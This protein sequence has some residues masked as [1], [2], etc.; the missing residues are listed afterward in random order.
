MFAALSVAGC[1]YYP[2]AQ[3]N[4]RTLISSLRTSLS[5]EQPE[6]LEQNVVE[7]D[8]RFQ[9]GELSQEEYDAFQSIIAKAKSGDWD[10][11]EVDSVAFQRAQVRS[12]D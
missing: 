1:N 5:T 2:Q 10:G 11:A 12:E 8:K 3:T 7:I 9:A 6:W 4:N